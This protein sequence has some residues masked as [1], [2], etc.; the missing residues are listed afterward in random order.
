MDY[1]Q[2]MSRLWAIY[3]SKRKNNWLEKRK[4]NPNSKKGQDA[5]NEDGQIKEEET[6]RDGLER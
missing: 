4:A 5:S 6:E 2:I 1:E 3:E